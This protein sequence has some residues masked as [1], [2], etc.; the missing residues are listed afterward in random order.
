MW[1][2]GGVD[3]EGSV[4]NTVHRWTPEEGFQAVEPRGNP[5]P[6]RWT[7]SAVV[8]GS[9]MYVFGGFYGYGGQGATGR[10]NDLWRLDLEQLSWAQVLAE[11][12]SHAPPSVRSHHS[13]AVLRDKMY[14]FGG[15]D[16]QKV[17]QASRGGFDLFRTLGG[18]ASAAAAGGDEFVDVLHNDLHEFDFATS[19]WRVV[20]ISTLLPPPPGGITARLATHRGLLYALCWR[21]LDPGEEPPYDLGPDARDG[22]ALEMAAIDLSPPKASSRA[23]TRAEQLPAWRKVPFKGSPPPARDLFSSAVWGDAWIVHAGRSVRGE[24][25]RDTYEFSFESRTWRQLVARGAG[26]GAPDCRYSHAA[27]VLGN[28]MYVVGGSNAAQHAQQQRALSQRCA[29]VEQLFLARTLAPSG[30]DYIPPIPALAPRTPRQRLLDGLSFLG[31][32]I[33]F[34]TAWALKRA[35]YE[36]VWA[37]PKASPSAD[38]AAGS[39][40]PARRIVVSDINLLV[41]GRRFHTHSDVLAA[42]SQ[43]FAAILARDP[44]AASLEAATQPLR[45]LEAWSLRRSAPPSALLALH[46]ALVLWTALVR[47]V[48]AVRRALFPGRA[49][50]IVVR[51]LSYDVAL[52]MMHFVYAAPGEAPPHVPSSLLEDCY[53]ASERYGVPAMRAACLGALVRGCG[54]QNCA[55][56]AALAQQHAC[57]PLWDAAVKAAAAALPVVVKTPG[58]EALWASNGRVAQQLTADAAKE[59]QEHSAGT[60]PHARSHKNAAAAPEHHYAPPPPEQQANAKGN[61]VV[62]GART[63]MLGGIDAAAQWLTKPVSDIFGAAGSGSSPKAGTVMPNKARALH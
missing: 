9:G 35:G 17:E 45:R 36:V 20:P 11:G 28:V 56:L 31:G 51:D 48:L 63:V 24:L 50:R 13:A 54:A 27:C 2:F 34:S 59:L 61:G 16:E 62:L 22:I 14:I 8:H 7:H 3:L 5:P 49:R 6:A 4:Y 55:R 57:E 30:D 21:A 32:G 46:A 43:R 23:R 18:G 42:A 44:A 1:Q 10:F 19:T 29:A 15:A 47:L 40:T 12:G 41:Q 38:G 26:H 37:Q 60:K 52:V 33:K 25:L 53:V 39:R 58:F